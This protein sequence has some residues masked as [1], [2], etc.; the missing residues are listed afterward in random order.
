MKTLYNVQ[1]PLSTLPY[2]PNYYV[3]ISSMTHANSFIHRN[4]APIFIHN[5]KALVIPIPSKNRMQCLCGKCREEHMSKQVSRYL[6]T[7]GS[8][9]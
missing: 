4:G 6:Q 1:V 8:K 9:S 3:A 5:G 2:T 7:K